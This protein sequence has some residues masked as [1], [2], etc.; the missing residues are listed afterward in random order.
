MLYGE[1]L[2]NSFDLTWWSS[3]G[4]FPPELSQ[5]VLRPPDRS[6]F[7]VS[8]IRWKIHFCARSD[9]DQGPS[10]RPWLHAEGETLEPPHHRQYPPKICSAPSHVIP[11]SAHK[12]IVP[13]CQ[14]E[15]SLSFR[16]FF[17]FSSLEAASGI[18]GCWPSWPQ[19]T[20][21][22]SSPST[23]TPPQPQES[24]G[25]HPEK[26][27]VDRVSFCSFADLV[28]LNLS[29]VDEIK[30]GGKIRAPHPPHVDQGVLVRVSP[31]HHLKPGKMCN[32]RFENESF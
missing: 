17:S 30:D 18:Q 6:S 5:P 19:L 28:H 13:E 24:L 14:A 8:K 7:Q 29:K 16:N 10:V 21:Q 4:S 32:S 22:G 27:K 25:V 12:Q 15:A 11:P 26:A 9:S 31:Q 20:C 1:G 3:T 2:I 23:S